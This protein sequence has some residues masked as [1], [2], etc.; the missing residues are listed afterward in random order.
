MPVNQSNNGKN[1]NSQTLE[2]EG[3]SEVEKVSQVV[4]E[5]ETKK[6]SDLDSGDRQKEL[7]EIEETSDR[8]SISPRLKIKITTLIGSAVVLPILAVG[9]AT[10]YFGSQAIDEQIASARRSN[11][12]IVQTELVRQQN[13]LTAL[14]IGTGTTALVAGAIAVSGTKRL[15]DGLDGQ[16]EISTSDQTQ[17]DESVPDF[18]W[19]KK[20]FQATVEEVRRDLN[21]DRVVVYSL[22]R[23]QY[24]VIVAESVVA[25]YTHAIGRKIDN[26][27]ETKYLDRYGN[28]RV[29]AIDDIERS[30]LSPD[31]R[32]QLK[33]LQ[34][35][36]NL[37]TPIVFQERLLGLLVAHQCS[38]PRK[39]QQSEIDLLHR[40]AEKASLTIENALVSD[41][42]IDL[43]TKT[44]RESKYTY[45]FNDAVRHIHRTLEPDKI[46]EIGVEEVHR[47]LK[48]DRVVVYS[49]EQDKYG[50][51][52][53]ESVSPDRSRALNK[54]IK[55]LD[56]YRDGKV[57]AINN[58][59]EAQLSQGYIEQLETLE[60]K[61][62]LV[63][64]ILNADKLFILVAHQCDRPRN[65]QD[66]EIRWMSSIATQIG[67][68]LDNARV[69]AEF[70]TVRDRAE[71]ERK[72]TY[73][74]DDVVRHIR[75][76]LESKDILN[77]SVE[78]V[79][80]VLKC[81]RVVVYSLQQ[82]NYGM[83]IAESVSAGRSRAENK[84][85]ADLDMYR[86]G[87]V[88]A[89]DNIY[90]AQLSLGYIEQLEALEVKAELVTPIVFQ[91]KSVLVAHQCDRQR[92]WLDYEIRWMSSVATQVGFA[93][94]NAI[95]LKKLQHNE[96]STQLLN[97]FSWKI[98]QAADKEL[99]NTAVEQVRKI[100]KLDRAVVYQFD[101]E[102]RAT[103]MAESVGSGYPQASLLKEYLTEESKNSPQVE[104]IADIHKSNL[105][106]RYLKQLELLGVKATITA[107]ILRDKQLFGLL[108]GHQCQQPRSWSQQ[109]TNL[110]T[111]LAL[112]TGSILDRVKLQEELIL[113]KNSQSERNYS[114][115]NNQVQTNSTIIVKPTEIEKLD[116]LEPDLYKMLGTLH[117]LRNSDRQIKR[118]EPTQL[119]IE[120]ITVEAEEIIDLENN[121]ELATITGEFVEKL[122]ASSQV[123]NLNQ[124]E[125]DITELSDRISQQS[126]F[127]TESF[128]KLA[129]LAKQL[130]EKDKK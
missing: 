89:I 32:E 33:Q 16:S 103:V 18:S 94:D 71:I 101:L 27:L 106:D 107:P 34:V 20:V 80:R 85:I 23:H 38:A 12:G 112:Q 91:G 79:H 95:L 39:W 47:I 59:Y 11:I 43:E 74:F 119:S 35:K 127:V 66:Y 84:T 37:V 56:L 76:S 67:F 111:Q 61:A 14:L 118:V 122:P 81:D 13:L 120:E 78:E 121:S 63:T 6:Q 48:C 10:Y 55:D 100:I 40:T 82:D 87:R 117:D 65:W 5:S 36:A 17:V 25:D 30:N 4:L 125:G 75:Q 26:P 126:L 108:I 69:L 68:A 124:S 1:I 2:T 53:A 45:C 50:V 115:L 77:I 123:I 70:A 22:D 21:C 41:R 8:D 51:V 49:L 64:P 98:S 116:L 109:E 113:R 96:R 28:D 15:I 83:V 72:W 86:D 44:E 46:L 54:A 110:F 7:I 128:Q 60:V 73:Y 9:T 24:G 42:L 31:E 3:N 102:G 19:Q 130:S 62:N 105:S 104:A 58:I 52:I 88:R 29:K 97:D 99:L 93:L 129:I 114:Q 57:R 92:N 90:E